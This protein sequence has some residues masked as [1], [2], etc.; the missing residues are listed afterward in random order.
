M[1]WGRQGDVLGSGSY[2]LGPK[3]RCSGVRIAMSWGRECDALGSRRQCSGIE[4]VVFWGQ[5]GLL[6]GS[7]SDALGSRL[8]CPGGRECDVLRSGTQ[9]WG[10]EEG[11]VLGS[12]LQC[13]GV[14]KV[15]FRECSW[16]EQVMFRSTA[17]SGA[18][19]LL[20]VSINRTKSSLEAGG[21]NVLAL[22]D[23]VSS[24][25]FASALS[26]AGVGQRLSSNAPRSEQSWKEAQNE[27]RF[28]VH[29]GHL[30]LSALNKHDAHGV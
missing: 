23:C 10:R 29:V 26:G 2:V 27:Q 19:I 15:M 18:Q 12:G 16:A 22:S 11:G 9:F 21:M 3:R 6:W 28:S 13:S 20:Q 30:P 5:E 7:E 4:T 14:E 17:T 1:F 8:Q 24:S 25:S